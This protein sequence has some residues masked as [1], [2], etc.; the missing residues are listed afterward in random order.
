MRC[1][2]YVIGTAT[3]VEQLMVWFDQLTLSLL[4]FV[5]IRIKF[6][7]TE[8]FS[9]GGL[10]GGGGKSACKWCNSKS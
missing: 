1:M 8:A 6:S 3:V 10:F 5:Q 9:K 4:H 7:W 2:H